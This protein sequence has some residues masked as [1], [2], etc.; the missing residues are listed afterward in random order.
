MDDPNSTCWEMLGVP[1]VSC[2]ARLHNDNVAVKRV[3]TSPVLNGQLGSEWPG[4][5]GVTK[6]F[7][8]AITTKVHLVKVK[9]IKRT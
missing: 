8:Q 9:H 5:V 7:T 2:V 1:D 3:Q 4:Y 6:F